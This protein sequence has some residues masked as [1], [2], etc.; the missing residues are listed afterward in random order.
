[1]KERCEEGGLLFSEGGA[2]PVEVTQNACSEHMQ[3]DYVEVLEQATRLIALPQCGEDGS[4]EAGT[5]KA[6]SSQILN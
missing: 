3:C 6:F 2:I 4:R 5:L 1:M